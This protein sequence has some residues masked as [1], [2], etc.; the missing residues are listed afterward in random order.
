M[1][2]LLN[3]DTGNS[4]RRIRIPGKGEFTIVLQKEDDSSNT[5]IIHSREAASGARAQPVDVPRNPYL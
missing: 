1:E 2:L 3:M 4:T 5:A